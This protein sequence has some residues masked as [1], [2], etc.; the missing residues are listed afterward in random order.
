VSATVSGGHAPGH[1]HSLVEA[2]EPAFASV[3]QEPGDK[4]D[5]T[6]RAHARRVAGILN[7]VEPIIG[8]AVKAGHVQVVAARYDLATGR[9]EILP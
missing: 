5:N 7:R 2:I 4:V 8:E 3:Q 1:I 6:V 9:I